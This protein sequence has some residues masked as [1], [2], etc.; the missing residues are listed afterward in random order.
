MLIWHYCEAKKTISSKVT[1]SHGSGRFYSHISSG[2]HVTKV[3]AL[4]YDCNL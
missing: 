4:A 3:S 1:N 2:S